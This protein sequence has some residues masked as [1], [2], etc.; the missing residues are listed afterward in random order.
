MRQH[1]PSIPWHLPGPVVISA[2]DGYGR[3]LIDQIRLLIVNI[4]P[5]PHGVGARH[6]RETRNI[7]DRY[8]RPHPLSVRS[9]RGGEFRVCGE[10]TLPERVVG[11][12]ADVV[13][14]DERR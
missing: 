12:E 3:R 8:L 10:K 11:S 2:D 4:E 14:T 9:A 5:H 6:Q 7:A 1:D 13:T